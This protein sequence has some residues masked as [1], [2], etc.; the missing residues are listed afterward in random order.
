[1]PNTSITQWGLDYASSASPS[2]TL[3]APLYWV[4][5]YD[6]RIDGLIHSSDLPVSAFSACV[7]PSATA[8]TG[9]IIWNVDGIDD[10]Y[11]LSDVDNVY[12]L[13]GSNTTLESPTLIGNPVQSQQWQINQLNGVPLAPHF[14]APEAYYTPA[15]NKW[16]TSATFTPVAW[17]NT[18]VLPG[19]N[20]YFQ[21]ID[22]YPV[23]ADAGDS[24]LRGT[25]KCRLAKDIGTVKFNKVAIYLTSFNNSGVESP[26]EPVLFA[27][28]QLKTTVIKTSMGTNGFDDVIVDVQ[29]DLHSIEANWNDVFFSTSGDYW[30]RVPD[31]VYYPERVG[32]GSFIDSI[33]SPQASLHVRRTRAMVG[34]GIT[35]APVARFDFNDTNYTEIDI[36]NTGE[37]HQAFASDYGYFGLI[38]RPLDK[39]IYPDTDD[40][41]LGTDNSRFGILK[42]S[43]QGIDIF[44]IVSYGYVKAYFADGTGII[45]ASDNVSMSFEALDFDP[46]FSQLSY[47]EGADIRRKNSHLLNYTAKNEEDSGREY[48]IIAD[49][50]EDSPIWAALPTDQTGITHINVAHVINNVSEANWISKTGKVKIYGRGEIDLNGPVML[51]AF[52]YNEDD[53]VPYEYGALMS[54]QNSILMVAAASTTPTDIIYAA[55]AADI[56]DNPNIAWGN[57]ISEMV[58]PGGEYIMISHI[59]HSGDLRPLIPNTSVIGVPELLDLSNTTLTQSSIL[60]KRLH[61]DTIGAYQGQSFDGSNNY[62]DGRVSTIYAKNI[63]TVDAGDVSRIERIAM[64]GLINI[65]SSNE[66]GSSSGFDFGYI[67]DDDNGTGDSAYPQNTSESYPFVAASHPK[68]YGLYPK[69]YVVLGNKQDMMNSVEEHGDL[70]YQS[71]KSTID[72]ICTRFMSMTST[73]RFENAFDI[74]G[75]YRASNPDNYYPGEDATGVTIDGSIPVSTTRMPGIH[76]IG[77][78]P[79]TLGDQNVPLDYAYID[80]ITAGSMTLTGALTIGGIRFAKTTSWSP[81]YTAISSV[82]TSATDGQKSSI[83][84]DVISLP[85][86]ATSDNSGGTSSSKRAYLKYQFINRLVVGY[87]D[88]V[89][90]YNSASP[91]QIIY[92]IY[93]ESTPSCSFVTISPAPTIW[94]WKAGQTLT[95]TGEVDKGIPTQNAVFNVGQYVVLTNQT[96][97]QYLPYQNI[98]ATSANSNMMYG[99]VT[100]F[101][102]SS[103]TYISIT[104]EILYYRMWSRNALYT[105]GN[106]PVT[107]NI[108]I[109]TAMPFLLAPPNNRLAYPTESTIYTGCHRVRTQTQ[110]SV[111]G[112]NNTIRGICFGDI[113]IK[114]DDAGATFNASDAIMPFSY[115]T[116]TPNNQVQPLGNSIDML[117]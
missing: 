32:I 15:N 28:C 76:K 84:T 24:R 21:V 41:L 35:D 97:I 22:Y 60:Y 85:M 99:V 2:G 90:N 18:P 3:I 52:A 94:T 101:T 36:S 16:N 11:Y 19:K 49:L 61:V 38:Y 102:A 89:T 103:A 53:S 100:S 114:A 27:E 107:G 12:I 45:K 46:V 13:S 37:V 43:Q 1:M 82:P 10:R 75:K 20:K 8:P 83:I 68:Y 58:L 9:E 42:L 65:G 40:V 112:V 79:I 88:T 50:I 55:A 93:S 72:L 116:I 113:G 74:I 31:G 62:A 47:I 81:D 54:R 73:L 4:P 25:I 115:L 30:A 17:D 69:N 105:V 78:M 98:G 33:L 70:L 23:S 5:V 111:Y 80:T 87:M 86:N 106:Q 39:T 96:P 91:N 108:R 26:N 57:L 14:S 29:L 63:G 117:A 48:V 6:S 77:S 92:P 66:I 51:D 110:D 7:N 64:S 104:I 67:R 59:R 44:D 95:Y 109:I 71:G 34:L 56:S